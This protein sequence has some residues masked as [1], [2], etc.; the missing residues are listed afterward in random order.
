[1]LLIHP[2]L[3]W[4]LQVS[5]VVRKVRSRVAS[6]L[7]FGSLSPVILCALYTAF[8]LPLCDYCAV[9]WSPTTSKFISMMERVHSKFTR[10][11]PPSCASKLSFT[12]IE[13]RRYHTAI[14]VFRSV[15]NYSPPYL[16]NIFHY[17]K[18]VTAYCGRNINHLFVTRVFNNFG[19]RS[20]VELYHGTVYYQLLLRLP[21]ANCL[22]LS[23][24]ILTPN[25]LF[26]LVYCVCVVA[27]FACILLTGLH[28]L[29]ISIS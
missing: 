6:L 29:K 15:H 28:A 2:L 1:M 24:C 17:S 27:I 11:L 10:K 14:Q 5:N 25:F 12:L 19:K 22:H 13:H 16:L 8:V 26:C 9:I 3:L 4:K 7:W 21:I 23:I 20:F 18:D